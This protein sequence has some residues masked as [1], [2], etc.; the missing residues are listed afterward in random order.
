VRITSSYPVII[1]EP[2]E[3][4]IIIKITEVKVTRD[5]QKIDIFKSEMQCR[6]NY[7]C[8]IARFRSIANKKHTITIKFEGVEPKL[9]AFNPKI[10]IGISGMYRVGRLQSNFIKITIIRLLGTGI[11]LIL[12][13]GL[14]REFIIKRYKQI[15]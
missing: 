12:I 13:F 3:P 1:N 2:I 9:Y 5:N 6:K 15:K 7:S 4:S 14:V 11:L 8:H 10:E